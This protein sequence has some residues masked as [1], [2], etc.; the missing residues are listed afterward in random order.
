MEPAEYAAGFLGERQREVIA[1]GLQVGVLCVCLSW[2]RSDCTGSPF[3]EK[4][5]HA[6]TMHHS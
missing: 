4:T 2:G 5:H 1:Y 6:H 3:K